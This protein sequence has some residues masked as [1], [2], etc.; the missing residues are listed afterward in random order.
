[1]QT[2]FV[3][4]ISA[5]PFAIALVLLAACGGGD[6]GASRLKKTHSGMPRDS[7][8]GVMGAGTVTATGSDSSRAV[9]GFRHQR[10][11]MN[12]QLHEIVWY[13]ETPGS[14]SEPIL[15]EAETPVV[16]VNDTLAGWGWK[17]YTDKGIKLGLPDV[18]KLNAM[19]AAAD[20]ARI[21]QDSINKAGQIYPTVV[22]DSAKPDST[23]K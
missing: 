5:A 7:V 16:L 11:L 23:R 18:L 13:R 1:M 4:R 3:R 2:S 10:F 8:L 15:K 17:Y 9:N 14:V 19:A 6:V 20:S 12:A 21:K 22:P